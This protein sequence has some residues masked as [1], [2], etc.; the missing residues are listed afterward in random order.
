L[1]IIWKKCRHTKPQ[2]SLGRGPIK[3]GV[4]RENISTG[5]HGLTNRD[6]LKEC[7]YFVG[8]HFALPK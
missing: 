3:K 2:R 1:Q 4:R 6:L 7:Y 5:G 8:I